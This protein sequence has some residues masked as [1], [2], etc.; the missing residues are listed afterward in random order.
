VS[1][2]P[3]NFLLLQTFFVIPASD[4]CEPIDE[5][6]KKNML[7]DV[8]MSLSSLL[9]IGFH[10]YPIFFRVTC[11]NLNMWAFIHKYTF[12]SPN[13]MITISIKLA[14]ESGIHGTS[15]KTIQHHQQNP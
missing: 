8:K 12:P 14:F 7:C 4:L 5:E 15:H 10:G 6:E 9:F 2:E 13:L 11:P 1:L 3:C